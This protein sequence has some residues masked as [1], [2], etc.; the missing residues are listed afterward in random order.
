[1]T[2]TVG[3]P[4]TVALLVS[5]PSFAGLSPAP[6]SVDVTLVEIVAVPGKILRRNQLKF[7]E[8]SRHICN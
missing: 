5:K 2:V 1:M 3:K 6:V 7:T 8:Q 4:A